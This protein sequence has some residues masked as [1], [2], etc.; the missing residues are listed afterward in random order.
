MNEKTKELLSEGVKYFREGKFDSAE[1]CFKEALEIEP[2]NALVHN[3]YALMLK[4]MEQCDRAEKHY[5]A[6]LEI[7]PMNTQIQ[8]NYGSLLKAKAK[9][10]ASKGKEV[11]K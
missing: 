2:K 9:T 7:E 4:R 11:K 3:N 8:K 5:K 1:Q 6:A 10:A